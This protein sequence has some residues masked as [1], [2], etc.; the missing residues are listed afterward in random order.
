M[1]VAHTKLS[2]RVLHDDEGQGDAGLDACREADR[3][4][5]VG[6]AAEVAADGAAFVLCLLRSSSDGIIEH[7]EQPSAGLTLHA[8]VPSCSLFLRGCADRMRGTSM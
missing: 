7:Q 3:E 1:L 4:A 8:Q 6:V 2:S 5:V